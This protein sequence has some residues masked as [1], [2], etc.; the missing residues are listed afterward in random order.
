MAIV[1]VTPDSFAHAC[2]TMSEQEVTDRIHAC[3]REGAHIL[4]IGG[5]STRPGHAIIDV[6]EEWRRVELGVRIAQQQLIAAG[7]TDIPISVDTYRAE[8]AQRAI[9]LGAHIINDVSGISDPDMP[10]VAARMHVPY[11]Y[12]YTRDGKNMLEEIARDIDRLHQAG[13]ADVIIDPGFG[14]G[15]T[16]QQNWDIMRRL[17]TLHE[18]GCPILVG[19]S[20]KSMIQR[21]LNVDAQQALTGTIATHMLALERGADILRVHDVQQA[22]ETIEIFR[23]C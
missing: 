15:K 22:R 16:L 18:L 6:R 23:Q 1:N 21:V 14:F 9:E 5:M 7:R 10:S 19:V 8:V 3:I 11:I 2:R 17:T 13:V 12:T 20:R 4:D